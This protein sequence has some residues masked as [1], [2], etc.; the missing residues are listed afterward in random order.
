MKGC[1]WAAKTACVFLDVPSNVCACLLR[2]SQ[3]HFIWPV[4]LLRSSMHYSHPSASML[5]RGS[6]LSAVA[7]ISQKPDSLP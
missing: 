4:R 3:Q 7:I 1:A 2:D 6:R 5:D